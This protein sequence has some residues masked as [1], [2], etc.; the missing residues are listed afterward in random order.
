MIPVSSVTCSPART[1]TR[2]LRLAKLF[3]VDLNKLDD[4][5]KEKYKLFEFVSSINHLTK[6][7]AP[8]QLIYASK[9]D[10]PITSQGIGIHHPKFGQALKERMDKL[11]IE[12][13]VHTGI[14]RGQALSDLTLAFVKKHFGLR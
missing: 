14:D 8:A 6:D 1:F 10:T 13:E 12:C 9:L 11:G 2:N 4:L 7:D 3:D 5:P